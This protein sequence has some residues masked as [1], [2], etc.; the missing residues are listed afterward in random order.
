MSLY[1]GVNLSYL[2]FFFLVYV[3]RTP[4]LT[5]SSLN[6]ALAAKYSASSGE[7]ADSTNTHPNSTP[8]K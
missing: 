3:L 1:A 2:S 5:M 7:L 6:T 4:R 8:L